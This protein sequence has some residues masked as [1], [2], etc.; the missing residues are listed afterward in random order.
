MRARSGD[1]WHE[2]A[3]PESGRWR[4]A[5]TR[6]RTRTSRASPSTSAGRGNLGNYRPKSRAVMAI[7]RA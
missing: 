7:V 5:T 6:P 3:L 4:T 1:G 2:G